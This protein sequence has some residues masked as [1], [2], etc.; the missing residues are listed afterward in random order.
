MSDYP[1]SHH[2]LAGKTVVVTAAAG[3][4]I[5]FATAKRCKEEGAEVLVSD[6]HERRLRATAELLGVPGV[7]C[8]VTDQASVDGLFNTSLAELG[9]IDVLVNNAGLGGTVELTEMTDEQWAKVID[10]TLTGTFR[11]TRAALQVMAPAGRGVIINNA[12]VLGWRAQ[13]G[14]AHYS[15]A[16]AGV[17]A[18][19]RSA[20]L[21][22][23]PRGVRVNAVSPSLA[24]HP[25][26]SKVMSTE[27]LEQLAAQEAFGRPAE[28]W[29]VANVIV[30]LAS[31]YSSYM[32]GEVVSVSSQH[33]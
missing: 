5:G 18:L 22:A 28:P 2:L 25:F 31:D 14:Q 6:A 21:E 13:A 16:K 33:P 7:V 12:S 30:F 17:M 11:C 4:G 10:V 32:T 9:R 29:E 26:L 24:M 20:A 3:T 27:A 8:D 1:P 15:A 19:T 23:A